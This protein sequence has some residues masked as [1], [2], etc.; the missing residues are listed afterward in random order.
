MN[1]RAKR[2]IPASV[3]NFDAL[4]NTARVDLPVVK[5]IT[6]KSR[7]TI[8]RWIEQGILPK[9][10]KVPGCQNSWIV[11]DL[12]AALGINPPTER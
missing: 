11:G 7:P 8:Y 5:A 1:Q 9:P 4:P 10:V 12:R 2:S 3:A 6:G